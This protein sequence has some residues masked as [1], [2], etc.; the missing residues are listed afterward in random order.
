M[1]LIKLHDYMITDGLRYLVMF[2]RID[3]VSVIGDLIIE[4]SF[5][6]IHQLI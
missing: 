1:K 6:S 5:S 3:R 2:V 4:L